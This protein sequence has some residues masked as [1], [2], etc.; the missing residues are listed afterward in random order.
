MVSISF[1]SF[2]A[3]FCTVQASSYLLPS[4]LVSD[5]AMLAS[6]FLQGSS[7]FNPFGKIQSWVL[8]V[9]EFMQIS[10]HHIDTPVLQLLRSKFLFSFKYEL[11]QF[12]L[13]VAINSFS[14]SETIKRLKFK[15]S[16]SSKMFFLAIFVNE[17]YSF[18]F[19]SHSNNAPYPSGKHLLI[20]NLLF[21]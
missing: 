1:F 4:A 16:W 3:S 18:I 20:H 5:M 17:E 2:I 8:L 10:L 9:K 14:P 19:L 7:V 21:V 6:Y 11:F 13:V 12:L 15:V